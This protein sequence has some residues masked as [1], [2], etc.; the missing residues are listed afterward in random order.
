MAQRKFGKTYK[1]DEFK[2]IN[3]EIKSF[4]TKTKEKGTVQVQEKLGQKYF[5]K[6]FLI[7]INL[8]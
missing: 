2:V 7:K 4:K 6:I 1:Y 5:K 8:E 3:K